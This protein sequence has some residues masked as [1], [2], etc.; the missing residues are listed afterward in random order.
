MFA[1]HREAKGKN[2][3]EMAWWAHREWSVRC[4][5]HLVMISHL[6]ARGGCILFWL[7]RPG[8]P[9]QHRIAG[10]KVHR[11]WNEGDTWTGFCT[12][13][14]RSYG[15]K[16]LLFPTVRTMRVLLLNPE[17]LLFLPVH[18]N[19]EKEIYR[20][21]KKYNSTFLNTCL[22]ISPETKF[23]SSS[24]CVCPQASSLPRSIT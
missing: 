3:G 18:W 23:C 14:E 16:N 19:N 8:I 15:G 7:P 11:F 12:T 17:P 5:C 22:H 2:K 6:A 1:R 24:P 13:G 10:M 4:Y 21:F 20:H 9:W